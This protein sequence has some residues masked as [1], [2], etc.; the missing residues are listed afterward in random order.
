[1]PFASADR[2]SISLQVVTA[3]AQAAAIAVAQSQLQSSITNFQGIDT[4][5]LNLMT[6]SN[7]L[8][9]GYHGEFSWIDGNGRTNIVEQ[10]IED[11]ANKKFQNH[12]FPNDAATAVPSITSIHNVWPLAVPYAM[13]YAIG[14]NY[15]E[16]YGTVSNNEASLITAIDSYT[17]STSP[18][19]IAAT[20]N[21]YITT[22]NTEVATIVTTDTNATN[23]ANNIA[24]VNNI[25]NVILP[26]LHSY[27]SSPNLGTLQTAANNRNT[28]LTTRKSQLSSVLGSLGQDITSGNVTGSGLY[29]TRYNFLKMRLNTLGGS[30][31][32]LVNALA[33]SGAQTS[34]TSNL[35][36]SA[37]T[38]SSMLPSTL[39]SAPANGTQSISLNDASFLSVGDTVYVMADSQTELQRAVKSISGKL[40]TLNDVVP[41][42][43]TTS[44]NARLYKDLT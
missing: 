16:T 34:I 23:K 12:F 22:L 35:N 3:P 1:M 24:A 17:G 15:T 39:L 40:V 31:S 43:Y 7:T 26:A 19:T 10:D 25:N 18:V 30:L 4:A 28:F 32:Q 9:T 27:L 44:N 5:N 2:I 42:K 41:A 37:S 14:K 11:A 33:A 13:T 38:Y 36:S 6:P 8:I 29:L 20:V 21:A